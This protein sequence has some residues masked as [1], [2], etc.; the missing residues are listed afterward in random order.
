V[1]GYGFALNNQLYNMVVGDPAVSGVHQGDATV[2]KCSD[3]QDL[4]H[5]LGT[6]CN[7]KV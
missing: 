3:G 7:K 1:Y 4:F 5:C 6:I 2:I